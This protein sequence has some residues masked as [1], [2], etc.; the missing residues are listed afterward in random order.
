MVSECQ[1]VSVQLVNRSR[2][3]EGAFGRVSLN[4]VKNAD[5]H[6][7]TGRVFTWDICVPKSCESHNDMLRFAQSLHFTNP[8]SKI[9]YTSPVCDVG[10]FADFKKM[11]WRGYLVFSIW[12]FM[13]GWGILASCVDLF[14]YDLVKDTYIPKTLWYKLFVALSIYRNIKSIFKLPKKPKHLVSEDGKQHPKSEVI[15]PLFCI[16]FISMIW[17]MV[18]HSFGFVLSTSAN[19]IDILPVLKDY[20]SQ[21]IPNAYFSVDSFFFMSGL[22]LSFI[23]F[24]QLAKNRRRT[25]GMPNWV[26]MYAHRILRLSPAY[27]MAIAFYTWVF[28][29]YFLKDMPVFLLSSFKGADSCEENWWVNFI[30][31]NNFIDSKHTC[32]LVSWY[33]ATDLQMFLFCPVILVPFAFGATL[34]ILVSSSIIILSTATTIFLTF[35]FRFPPADFAG[36]WMDPNMTVDYNYY[37]E[38][39]Y[40]NPATR[41]QVYIIGMMV[42]WLLIHKKHIKINFF[43][44]IFLW[45]VSLVV[46]VADVIAIRSWVSGQ[47]MELFPR[48]MY[49]AFSKPAWALCLSWIIISCYY[50]YGGFINKFM[51]MGIWV[52]PGRVVY[53]AYLIHLMVIIYVMGN[54]RELLVF[55][56][57]WNTLIFVILPIVFLSFTIA[58]G[59]SAIFEIGVGKIEDLLLDRKGEHRPRV[60]K[61]DEENAVVPKEVNNGWD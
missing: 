30:Y 61:G 26:M 45:I 8:K 38:F 27:Y 60:K 35:H 52:A 17:V 12:C 7:Q 6:C 22:L 31:L 18:G 1:A 4:L 23:F 46:M 43:L 49:A 47:E 28:I 24:K 16:R 11:T 3:F 14:I 42:G 5:G 37:T 48:A 50:G 32:Y 29:P 21:W 13:V 25:L 41:C 56:S 53:S 33:L 58:F 15:S 19:P 20:G 10:T 40:A 39:M 54:F 57:V 55:Y 59:W 9:N 2:I 36:G 34:G 51:S 44:N